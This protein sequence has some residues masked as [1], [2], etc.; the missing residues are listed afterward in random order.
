MGKRDTLE[1]KFARGIGKSLAKQKKRVIRN[2]KKLTNE[3]WK[4]EDQT[5]MKEVRPFIKAIVLDAIENLEFRTKN[6]GD[7][8]NKVGQ[9]QLEIIG[10]DPTMIFEEVLRVIDEYI[11]RLIKGGKVLID[12][13]EVF[14]QGINETTRTSVQKALTRF[15]TI[16]DIR[17][18][19]MVEELEPIFGA[20]RASKI[21]VTETTRAYS[22]AQLMQVAEIEKQ[23]IGMV[24]VW[25]TARDEIVARCPICYPLEQMF[26][27][28]REGGEPRWRHPEL[29]KVLGPPPAHV[30]CRCA[31]G[32]TYQGIAEGRVTAEEE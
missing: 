13:Q 10:F 28:H 30:N 16:P 17:I 3:F 15:A 29:P 9:K 19:D 2:R 12:G 4:K 23:G 25:S 31:I 8:T 26:E 7:I 14:I 11:F 20:A 22:Q 21:A 32:H 24:A 1:R 18:V 6:V 27:T 5:M